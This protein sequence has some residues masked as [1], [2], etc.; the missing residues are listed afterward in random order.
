[1]GDLPDELPISRVPALAKCPEL[2]GYKTLGDLR[3][4]PP[5][6]VPTPPSAPPVSYDTETREAP[7]SAPKG[8]GKPTDEQYRAFQLLFDHL[9]ERLFGGELPHVLL[10]LSSARSKKVMAFFLPEG[11][12]RRSGGGTVT[13]EIAVCPSH[14]HDAKRLAA[15]VAHEMVH[16]AQLIHGTAARRGYHNRDFAARSE[17]VGIPIPI[18]GQSVWLEITPG[19]AFDQ[20][21]AELPEGAMLPLITSY[22]AVDEES[23]PSPENPDAGDGEE[24][25]DDEEPESEPEPADPSK[26]KYTCPTCGFNAWHRLRRETERTL[27]CPHDGAY[28]PMVRAITDERSREGRAVDRAG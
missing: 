11:W 17:A 20:A 10:T 12:K 15:N 2:A 22:P 7:K 26:V 1:L 3:R 14:T 19:G 21:Y 9:N 13:H 23:G 5:R 6:L 24:G 18:L 27:G 4:S 25:S 8:G 16:L 28:V